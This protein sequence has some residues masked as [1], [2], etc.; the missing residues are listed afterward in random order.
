MIDLS[1]IKAQLKQVK[2]YEDDGLAKNPTIEISCV[3]MTE[4][5]QALEQAKNLLSKAALTDCNYKCNPKSCEL[6][7]W[8]ENYFPHQNK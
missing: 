5:I 2:E 6:K 8:F 7:A 4:I 3:E 1:Q